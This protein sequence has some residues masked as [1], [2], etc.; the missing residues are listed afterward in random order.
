VKFL[1]NCISLVFL[2]LSL[3]AT[4][5]CTTVAPPE[6]PSGAAAVPIRSAAA[7]A[8][9]VA[10]PGKPS[11]A[12]A[13]PISAAAASTLPVAAAYIIGPGDSLQVFVWRNAELSSTVPVRPDGKISTPL[14]EDMV[15]VGKTPTQLARDIEKV[16]AEYVKS[17]QV[18][19]IVT[20][21]LS[22]FSQVK[23]IGQ[24]VKPQSLP[25]REGMTVLDALLTVGGLGPFAAG[26]RA[27]VVR[28][29]GGKQ[30]EIGVNLGKIIDKGDMTQNLKLQPGDVIVVPET[31]F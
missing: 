4:V 3:C 23:V 15:A 12:A 16:L 10:P 31:R 18:N 7:P 2:T 14:V 11:V 19:V 22:A 25:Y 8:L 24:V 26:N 21:P 28:T 1:S 20:Q 30:T 5:A 13:A 29:V 27:K 17:P 6:K 9:P